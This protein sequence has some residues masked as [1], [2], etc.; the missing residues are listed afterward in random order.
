MNRKVLVVFVA[1]MAVAMLATPIAVAKP[2]AEKNNEKFEFFKLLCSG[3]GTDTYEKG[4]ASPPEG[5]PPNTFHGR[6]G[7]WDASTV[8]IV[9]LTVGGETFTK[10]TAPYHVDYTTT[11]DIEVHVDK[12][13]ITKSYNIRLTDVVTVYRGTGVIGTLILN[14]AAVVEFTDGEPSGYAGTVQGYGT[15]ELQGVH[16]SAEDL[17]VVGVDVVPGNPPV[18]TVLYARVGTITGWPAEITNT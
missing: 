8:R 15:E 7:G 11:F 17:G 5:A 6:G 4:W 12:A 3:E 10:I 13:G 16:I 9:E 18:V 14:I 1:L 2:G